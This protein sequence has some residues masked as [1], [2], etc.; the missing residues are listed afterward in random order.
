MG[1]MPIA[2]VFDYDGVL[3]DT[4]RLH[5]KSWAALFLPYDLRLTWDE[6]CRIG[7]G[8]ADDQMFRSIMKNAPDLDLNMEELARLNEERKREV[9]A[10]SLAESPI[11]QETI[12]LLATLKAYRIGLVTS[13]ERSY[14]EPVLR[15]SA[16]Y[17]KFDALV[18]GEDVPI[19][20]PT[21]DPY[22]LIAKWLGASTGIA[23]E[24]SDSGLESARAAGFKAVRIEHPTDLAQV[25]AQSLRD[26]AALKNSSAPGNAWEV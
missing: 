19:H 22:L 20:K 24:D 16:I 6:Y 18:F 4:E 8:F 26:H 14:V 13:S 2:L 23:F 5:W 15:A 25:V 9:R 10:W 3:A 7:R 1:E 11:P 17:E 21:P 12:E